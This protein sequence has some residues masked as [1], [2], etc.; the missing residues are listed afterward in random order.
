[1]SYKKSYQ[2]RIGTSL[3]GYIPA[4]YAALVTLFGEPTPH[5]DGYK[6]STEWVLESEAGAVITLYD[7][8]ETNLYCADY[9]TVEEFRKAPSYD[10]HIGATSEKAAG[11]FLIWI[12]EELNRMKSKGL[13]ETK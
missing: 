8:K 12:R 6:V 11:P 3:K 1:M 5:I 7:Y 2:S 4:S 10:W 13:T 9:P